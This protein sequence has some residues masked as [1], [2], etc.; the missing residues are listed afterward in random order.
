[1]SNYVITK[2][3]GVSSEEAAKLRNVLYQV[4]IEVWLGKCKDNTEDTEDMKHLSNLLNRKW[5]TVT[6]TIDKEK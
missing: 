2:I 1:M 5:T 6:I 4:P 3:E